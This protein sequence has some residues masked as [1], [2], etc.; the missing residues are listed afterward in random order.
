[1][2]AGELGDPIREEPWQ[3]EPP[4]TTPAPIETVPEPEPAKVD[5]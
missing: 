4:L 3:V 5:A 2:R 1:M